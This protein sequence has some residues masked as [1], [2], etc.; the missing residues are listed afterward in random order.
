METKYKSQ[1]HMKAPLHC[2]N[3]WHRNALFTLYYSIN[4]CQKNYL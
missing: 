1:L 3:K 4:H 2:S